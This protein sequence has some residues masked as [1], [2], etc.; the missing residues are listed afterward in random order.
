MP[1]AEYK[2]LPV[3]DAW[4]MEW[5]DVSVSEK[6]AA[7][8]L[9]PEIQ[10]AFRKYLTG[11]SPILEAGCGL[12]G[13][14]NYLAKKKF[15]VV[16]LDYL[17]PVIRKVRDNDNSLVLL[18]ADAKALP[19]RDES[20]R[21]ALS[22]GVVEHIE[23]GPREAILDL[24]RVT[25]PDG[26]AFISVP[27]PLAAF[28]IDRAK[29]KLKRNPLVRKLLGRDAYRADDR[30]FQ[31]VFSRSEFRGIL[32]ESGC[33]IVDHFPYGFT[34]TLYYCFPF[35]RSGGNRWDYRLNSI[36]RA[37]SR[38]VRKYRLWS[39]GQMQMAVVRKIAPG[40]RQ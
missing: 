37:I 24:L 8:D 9:Y 25:T 23:E 13:W 36:G 20:F 2:S 5:K 17:E 19:F 27:H 40:A 18:V 38:L 21:Y 11:E 12:G 6:V 16:G 15:P 14:V 10:E 34:P 33:E 30:F 3:K 7:V 1:Y 32:R 4:G 22:L 31:Y 26:L 29:A 39:F 35:L 28:W